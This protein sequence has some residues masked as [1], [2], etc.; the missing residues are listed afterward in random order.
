MSG[1]GIKVRVMNMIRGKKVLSFCLVLALCLG[2]T[3]T[4]HAEDISD[5]KKKQEELESQKSAAEAEKSSLAAALNQ[6][7]SEMEQAQ[8]DLDVKQIEI[9]Q[10]QDELDVAKINENE[11]YNSMKLRIKYMYENGNTQFIE[12]LAESSDMGDFLNKAEYIKQV[13]DYDRKMLDE[14]QD[15]VKQVEEKEAQLK[16]EEEELTTLQAALIEKQG[17]VETMLADKNAELSSLEAEMGENASKLQEMIARA[18]AEKAR[19]AEILASQKQDNI[20]TPSGDKVIGNGKLSWPCDSTRITSY[21][22]KRPVPVAGATSNHDAIDIGAPSGSPVY[23]ADG[24]TVT[25]ASVG[26]NGGRGNYI[27]VNHGNGI[28]TRYQHLSSIYVSVGQTVSRGQ[29]IAAVGNTG[30]SSGPHLDFA[31]YVNGSTVNPLT[32]L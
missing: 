22:G 12:I 19:Q 27:M 4:A 21:Y 14:F 24:G 17:E 26:Y 32:Y 16:V 11:Q 20:G 23:A 31:V 8:A 7:V 15:I 6:V 9:Q 28:V 18:E 29:N 3:M 1:L 30:A 2:G 5:V 13:S 10:A 25:T